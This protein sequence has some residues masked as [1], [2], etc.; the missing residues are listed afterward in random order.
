[1]VFITPIF[2][3]SLSLFLSR[4]PSLSVIASRMSSETSCVYKELMN[5]SF[6]LSVN[7][8]LSMCRSSWKNIFYEVVLTTAEVFSKTIFI[9]LDDQ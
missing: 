2:M 3:N 8:G 5:A 7:T 6:S 4:H 9:F 1:M